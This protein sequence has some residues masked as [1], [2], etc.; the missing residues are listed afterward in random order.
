MNQ[1]RFK[2]L[3]GIFLARMTILFGKLC[4]KKTRREELLKVKLFPV[5]SL[6]LSF[7]WQGKISRMMGEWTGSEGMRNSEA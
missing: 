6:S 2:M 1:K 7:L 5:L 4:L 3:S